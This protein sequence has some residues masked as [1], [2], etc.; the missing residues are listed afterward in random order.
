VNPLYIADNTAMSV[1]IIVFSEMITN[2]AV[3]RGIQIG[4]C[5]AEKSAC[6]DLVYACAGHLTR[7]SHPC[8]FTKARSSF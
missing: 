6:D 8:R 4:L 7:H 1:H 5:R 2:D 3:V